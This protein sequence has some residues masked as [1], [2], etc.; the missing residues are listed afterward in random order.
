MTEQPLSPFDPKQLQHTLADLLSVHDWLRWAVSRFHQAGVY[1]G[2]GTD[3]AWDEAAVLLAHVLYLPPLTD[4]KLL[5]V[6]LD[7]AEREA[8]VALLQQRIEQRSPAAY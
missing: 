4:D 2:H 3:N 5:T 6:K 8:F 1:F 7:K